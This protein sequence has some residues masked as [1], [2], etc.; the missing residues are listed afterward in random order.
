VKGAEFGYR[1]ERR[2][3]VL[4]RVVQ[5]SLV[6]TRFKE[7]VTLLRSVVPGSTNLSAISIVLAGL[8]CGHY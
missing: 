5:S 7:L 8:R 6:E 3:Q 4:G 2:V 1:K